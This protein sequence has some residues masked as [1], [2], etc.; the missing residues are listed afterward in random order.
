MLLQLLP[1]RF[2]DLAHDFALSDLTLEKFLERPLLRSMISKVELE[3]LR[4]I[5]SDFDTVHKMALEFYR[6]TDV[7]A[8]TIVNNSITHMHR[9]GLTVAALSTG[10]HLK[11]QI[12]RLL[13]Q[14]KIS[15]VVIMC[16]SKEGFT[17][18][19]YIAALLKGLEKIRKF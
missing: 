13:Q 11:E 10:G 8:E 5:Q 17:E 16:R 3:R 1:N 2:G 4:D 15:Y 12:V 7:R 18:N 9:N 14:L 19:D 6:V